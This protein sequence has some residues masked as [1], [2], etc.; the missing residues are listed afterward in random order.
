MEHFIY[1]DELDR[2]DLGDG[3]WV[4]IAKRMS[5]GM[6]QKLFAHYVK[7]GK[8]MKAIDVDIESGN[9]T[10]L[11]VNIKAWNLKG[12]DGK[13]APITKEVVAR[14]DPVIANKVVEE[15]NNRNPS[16]KA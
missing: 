14:L 5:Y 6:Q 2:I 8:D 4:D 15:I 11:L 3:E 9:L 1:E 7:L 13:V 16:P 10:L 12:K